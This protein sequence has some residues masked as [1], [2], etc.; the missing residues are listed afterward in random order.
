MARRVRAFCSEIA[1]AADLL[2]MRLTFLA[3][4]KSDSSRMLLAIALAASTLTGLAACESTSEGRPSSTKPS[5]KKSPAQW[6]MIEGA[7]DEEVMIVV[8]E[9][10]EE[11][12]DDGD[13][14]GDEDGDDEGDKRGEGNGRSS[15]RSREIRREIFV[16]GRP[17][18]NA[19]PMIPTTGMDPG[20][21]W[22][23]VGGPDG[24]FIGG[25]AGDHMMFVESG[26]SALI[27]PGVMPNSG[28]PSAA[29]PPAGP[30]VSQVPHLPPVMLGVRMREVDPVL[31]THLG[32]NPR[33]CSVL[34]DV[35]EELSGHG[36]GLRDHDIITSVDGSDD[37]SPSHIRRV[38]RSKKP[39][40]TITFGGIRGGD[41]TF[42]ATVTLE[43][44]DH[45]K[46][47]S[48]TPARVGG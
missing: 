41:A 44:F 29:M 3:E 11:Y 25:P 17:L 47:L 4:P 26:A 12:D 38:L 20:M 2:T 37:A 39:G 33:K 23:P 40:D 45:G 16:E 42:D 28:Q 21:Q 19:G 10:D 5:S 27:P 15:R 18:S 32:L 6:S 36:G 9:R 7:E 34:E 48:V 46:L 1:W 14:D 35:S 22:H 43:P 31:A 13:D 30:H 8:V 24:V